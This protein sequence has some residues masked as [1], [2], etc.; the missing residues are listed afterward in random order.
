MALVK[1]KECDHEISDKASTCPQCG[2]PQEN[3]PKEIEEPKGPKQYSLGGLLMLIAFVWF[4][5][6]MINGVT[7]T[8]TAV[9]DPIQQAINKLKLDFT[10]RTTTGNAFMEANFTINNKGSRAVKDIEITCR[11]SA[12]SGTFI[13]KNTR[14]IY[15]VVKANTTKTFEKFDMGLI[16]DQVESSSCK[17]IK[18][19]VL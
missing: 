9:H 5:W 19:V 17:I 1:C 12:K 7:E 13:D 8:K 11:H 14:T 10:W 2:A 6:S 18:L 4:I 3:K 15:D 16:R